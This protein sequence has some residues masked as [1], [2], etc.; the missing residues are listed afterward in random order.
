MKNQLSQITQDLAAGVAKTAPPVA[1]TVATYTEG[2]TLSH[3]AAIATIVY[4]IVLTLTTIMKNW[5]DWMG[6]WT[7]RI[8]AG[9]RLYAMVRRRG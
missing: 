7:G 2:L 9:R 6:W 8:A 4:T 3:W 5:G 1:V